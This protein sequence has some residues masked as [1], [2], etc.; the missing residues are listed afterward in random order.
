MKDPIVQAI[1][2]RRADYAK[3]F[4]YDVHAIGED[5][6]RCEAES[7]GRFAAD[8]PQG[9]RPL[10]RKRAKGGRRALSKTSCSLSRSGVMYLSRLPG[11]N[12]SSGLALT[13]VKVK[14]PLP[15]SSKTQT[16]LGFAR[17]ILMRL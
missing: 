3:R 4:N 13:G 11:G 2:R 6:R 9:K 17:G 1:H 8:V 16:C 10:P 14:L 5:I 12:G 15:W 7:G